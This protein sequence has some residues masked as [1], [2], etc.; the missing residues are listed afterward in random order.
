MTEHTV[1]TIAGIV[2]TISVGFCLLLCLLGLVVHYGARKHKIAS[3]LF[4]WSAAS[5]FIAFAVPV[6]G[7]AI[8]MIAGLE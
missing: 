8:A 5:C 6:L 2:V 1:M 4:G 3:I 7:K